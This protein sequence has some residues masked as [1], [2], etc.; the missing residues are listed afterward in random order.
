MRRPKDQGAMTKVE[1]AWEKEIKAIKQKIGDNENKIQEIKQK[2]NNVYL[3]RFF[4]IRLFFR[5]LYRGEMRPL[6]S[7]FSLVQCTKQAQMTQEWRFTSKHKK[8]KTLHCRKDIQKIFR[9]NWRAWR[10]FRATALE[11]WSERPPD[12]PKWSNE[13]LPWYPCV[14]QSLFALTFFFFFFSRSRS[15]LFQSLLFRCFLSQICSSFSFSF[16]K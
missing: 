14:L 4:L 9:R 15:L 6:S 11:K 1:K 8:P 5:G 16:A 3:G 12:V 13:N 10:R 7:P 2:L